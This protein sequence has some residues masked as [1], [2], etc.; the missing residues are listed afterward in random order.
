[1]YSHSVRAGP[2]RSPTARGRGPPVVSADTRLRWARH[3]RATRG[4]VDCTASDSGKPAGELSGSWPGAAAA[5]TRGV[6]RP[7][8]RASRAAQARRSRGW[9]RRR[10]RRLG[11]ARRGAAIADA[12]AA[13]D[14]DDDA[15]AAPCLRCP[16]CPSRAW[17]CCCCCCSAMMLACSRLGKSSTGGPSARSGA[18]AVCLVPTAARAARAV[19]RTGG[20]T[21][22]VPAGRGRAPRVGRVCERGEGGSQE[23]ERESGSWTGVCLHL[24]VCL[25]GE[26]VAGRAPVLCFCLGWWR[27]VD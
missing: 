27:V 24:S 11:G 1:V 26:V 3:C 9:R 21:R 25:S 2:S 15:A 14:D 4:R 12:A 16:R 18:A 7:D 17:C 20:V 6:G 19:A 8:R 10:Q 23:G 22:R 5:A 13:A